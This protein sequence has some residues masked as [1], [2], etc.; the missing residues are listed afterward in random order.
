LLAGV[1]L[2][3]RKAEFSISSHDVVLSLKKGALAV[4][5]TPSHI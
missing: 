5:K 1:K 4:T 3:G 2:A